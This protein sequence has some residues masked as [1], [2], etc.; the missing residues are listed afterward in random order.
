MASI[1]DVAVRAGVGIGTVSR[2][3]NN[4]GYVS[5]ETRLRIMKAVEEIGYKPSAIATNMV[6]KRTGIIGVMVP[7]LEHPFFAKIMK[8][9]ENELYKQGY[10]CLICNTLDIVNRQKSFID[11]LDSRAV[12]GIISCVDELP[13]FSNSTRGAIVSFDRNSEAGVPIVRSDHEMGGRL[14]AELFIKKGCKK[15]CQFTAGLDKKRTANI[16]HEVMKE[17]LEEAG[18]EVISVITAWDALSYSYNKEMV[19]NYWDII[20]RVDGIMTTDIGAL[21]C[22]AVAQKKGFRIPNDL[23][24]VAYDGTEITELSYPELT[25]IQQNCPEI[26]RRCVETVIKMIDGEKVPELELVPVKLIERGTT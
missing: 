10:K 9:I 22:L 13:D 25:V 21:S 6:K 1:R 23:C 19:H 4:S 14:V 24:I 2:T 8:H 12:D 16:R 11:M 7:N 15:V 5:E 26:A 20:E 3:L 17:V 18:V